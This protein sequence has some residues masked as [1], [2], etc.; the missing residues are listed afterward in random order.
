MV[1]KVTYTDITNKQTNGESGAALVNDL[2]RAVNELIDV[3]AA[4]N[5]TGSVA[6]LPSYQPR[7][8]GDGVK[9]TFNTPATGTSG[10]L[11]TN[12]T[13]Y[14]NYVW[15]RPET[16]F[17]IDSATGNLTLVDSAVPYAPNLNDTIDISY[18]SPYIP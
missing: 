15:Q 13:V 16:D 9:T 17:T 18:T 6:T 7:Q 10:A 11:S 8:L 3:V 2:K 14:L 5:V 12:F 1:S 4:I